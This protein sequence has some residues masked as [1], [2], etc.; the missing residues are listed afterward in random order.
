MSVIKKML[1]SEKSARTAEV[2]NT[3]VFVVDRSASKDAIRQ[4]LKAQ[5]GVDAVSV[6][7]TTSPGKWRRTARSQKKL[8]PI[9]KAYVRLKK[10][11]SVDVFAESAQ[12][13]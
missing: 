4:E 10:G 8:A 7:T 12:G 1:I 5:F 13:A 11:Q 9:K 2:A 3:F 6:N